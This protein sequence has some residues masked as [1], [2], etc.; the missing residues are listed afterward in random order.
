MDNLKSGTPY[1]AALYGMLTPPERAEVLEKIRLGD[2]A[3]L[4]VSPEQL[5]DLSFEQA[6]RHREIGCRVF[7]EARCLSKWGFSARLLPGRQP[8]AERPSPTGGLLHGHGQAHRRR[9]RA[10]GALRKRPG[11]GWY[12]E[13]GR[14]RDAHRH[15]GVGALRLSHGQVGEVGAGQLCLL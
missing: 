2:V 7:D 11:A 6:I 12:D 9:L 3:I 14:L 15:G 1:D 5:R 8:G 4:Y 13:H 10:G